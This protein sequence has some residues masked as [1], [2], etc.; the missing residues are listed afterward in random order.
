LGTVKFEKSV[1]DSIPSHVLDMY[2]R[3][4]I[5]L[6][7][8]KKKR[9]EILIDEIVV[10]PLATHGVRFSAFSSYML[11]MDL[12]IVGLSHSQGLFGRTNHKNHLRAET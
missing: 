12:R 8:G 7:R 9:D 11:P 2:S 6:L 10:P 3:E 5:L 4:A 1:A